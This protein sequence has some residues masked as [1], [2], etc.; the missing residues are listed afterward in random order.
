MSASTT[1]LPL[2]SAS[3]E[4]KKVS[5][6]L[7][8][9]PVSVAAAG[10]SSSS[11]GNG[12]GNGQTS[13]EGDKLVEERNGTSDQA[14]QPAPPKK[15]SYLP[16]WLLESKAMVEASARHRESVEQKLTSLRSGIETLGETIDAHHQRNAIN[17]SRKKKGLPPIGT[18]V[19]IKK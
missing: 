14:M 12:E 18:A 13:K 16:A 9:S 2:I 8:P 17:E 1:V 15:R 11:E 19:R 5:T 3:A 7:T 6:L 10:V 4:A